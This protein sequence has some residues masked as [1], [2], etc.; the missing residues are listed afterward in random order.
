[1]SSTGRSW[2]TAV[3]ALAAVVLT[4]GASRAGGIT[5]PPTLEVDAG[6]NF[7]A[8]T[9]GS[10]TTVTIPEGFFG[11]KNGT[12][13]DA[14]VD[15]R[16]ELEG[17]PIGKMGLSPSSGLVVAAGNCHSGGGHHHCHKATPLSADIDTITKVSAATL[18]RIGDRADVTLQIVAL[19]LQTPE[20]A[21]LKVTYGEEEPS[22]LRAVLTLDGSE[23]PVGSITLTRTRVDGGIMEVDLPVDFNVIFT[24]GPSERFGPVSLET[25]LAS[26]DNGFTIAGE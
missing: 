20:S 8:T 3:L 21:P 4:A 5:P 24:G 2:Q 7:L 23:Q 16:V 26:D 15:R 19:S 12:P 14:I 1:M 11:E 9:P 10:F 25:V 18:N 13:S 17:R 22:Y 6:Y